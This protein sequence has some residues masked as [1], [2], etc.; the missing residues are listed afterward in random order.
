[1][2]ELLDVSN[3]LEVSKIREKLVDEPDLLAM[4]KLLII[5][6]NQRLNDK[7]VDKFIRTMAMEVAQ[8]IELSDHS[9]DEEE[10]DM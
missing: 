2:P 4:F 5:I 7:S 1:M 9:S 10:G 3:I 6:S 8:H